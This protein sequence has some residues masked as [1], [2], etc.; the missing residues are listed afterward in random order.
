MSQSENSDASDGGVPGADNPAYGVSDRLLPQVKAFIAVFWSWPRRAWLFFY[1]AAIVAVICVTVAGQLRLNAWYKD[2]YNAIEQFNL[3]EFTNQLL[4]F[5]LI[6][7]G[8][9]VLNVAQTWLNQMIKLRG[10]ECLTRDLVSQ[11]LMPK[12]DFL[13]VA[14]G[15]I[16]RNPDQRIHEDARHLIELSTD[17]AMGF[18]QALLLLVSF[19]GVLWFLSRGVVFS[20]DHKELVIPG[21]MVWCALLYAAVGSVLSWAVGRPLVALNVERYAREADLRFALVRTNENVDG[22][23]LY[24]GEANETRRLNLEIDRLLATIRRIVTAITRLTWV[25]AGYGWFAIVIPILAAAPGYFEHHLSFGDLMMVAGAFNQVQQSLRWFVDNFSSLADWRATLRR[26]IGFRQSLA[27]LDQESGQ[28]SRISIARSPSNLMV[29]DKLVVRFP[30]G[31]AALE[32]RSF[33]VAPGEHVLILGRARSGKSYIFRAVA[34]LWPWGSGTISIPRGARVSFLPQRPYVPPDSLR[35]SLCYPVIP[36]APDDAALAAALRRVGL[37]DLTPSLDKIARWDRDLTLEA[38]QRL[39]FA[40]LLLAK[41]DF[42]FLDE[43]FDILEED[44]R[45]MAYSLFENELSKA[46]VISFT[47]HEAEGG[48][49]KRD[50]RIVRVVPEV[51]AEARSEGPGVLSADRSGDQQSTVATL[52]AQSGKV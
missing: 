50:V 37:S 42:V 10:R 11:W 51:A 17:L 4:V 25:T 31:A 47:R 14:A 8:I 5:V 36:G 16:G 38:Q 3:A 32:P 35:A 44:C 13:L 33:E 23:S 28:R 26:V 9:L 39:A 52:G 21:Y 30:D 48:S 1:I 12:R 6:V 2:F 7:S 43:A 41:P 27:T 20:L 49:F 24:R 15:A 22:I 46:A 34:G 45:Q 18:V 29:F 40:R 19:I